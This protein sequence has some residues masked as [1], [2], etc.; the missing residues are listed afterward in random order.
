[1]LP[2]QVLKAFV[3]GKV[4]V[5][6]FANAS[7]LKGRDTY[8]AYDGAHLLGY[9]RTERQFYEFNRCVALFWQGM[10]WEARCV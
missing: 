6:L 8:H 4:T 3:P 5:T 9:K 10:R 7:A 2:A 1:M